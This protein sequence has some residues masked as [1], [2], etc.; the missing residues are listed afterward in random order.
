MRCSDICSTILEKTKTGLHQYAAFHE[1]RFGCTISEGMDT[2]RTD[3]LR[4][5]SVKELTGDI[6]IDDFNTLNPTDIIFTTPEKLDSITRRRK[7]NG[8]M[9]VPVLSPGELCNIPTR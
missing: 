5:T 9:C 4:C 1:S 8:S 7:D 6:D 2:K 3:K